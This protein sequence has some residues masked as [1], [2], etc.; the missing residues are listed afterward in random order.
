MKVLS[1][2]YIIC[3][4]FLRGGIVSISQVQQP[5]LRKKKKGDCAWGRRGSEWVAKVRV[6]EFQASCPDPAIPPWSGPALN[7]NSL[8]IS[9]QGF[10][11][12]FTRDFKGMSYTKLTAHQEKAITA[13][14]LHP[15]SL[16]QFTH[17]SQSKD[18]QCYNLVNSSSDKSLSQDFLHY[19]SFLHGTNISFFS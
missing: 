7:T 19:T 6:L 18:S 16:L 13:P 12:I 9:G 10:P 5:K 2:T 11:R 3:K 15:N 17:Y 1:S 14:A 4:T 8:L